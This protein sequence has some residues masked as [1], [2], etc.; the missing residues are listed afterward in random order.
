MKHS[1]LGLF[2]PRK[3]FV[4]DEEDAVRAAPAVRHEFLDY[5]VANGLISQTV[6][7]A[8]A[9]EQTVTN[10]LTGAILVKHNYITHQA[11]TKAILNF[12]P[13]RIAAEKAATSRIP[14]ALLRAKKIHIAHSDADTIYVASLMD[15]AEVAPLIEEYYPDKSIAWVAFIP[16]LFK[17]F[18]DQI[19]RATNAGALTAGEPEQILTY[20]VTRAISEQ[21][22]DIHVE[23]KSDSYTVLFRKL[24]VRELIYEGSRDEY[25]S[26]IARLKDRSGL[27]IAQ[28][29]TAQDGRFEIDYGPKRVDLRVATTVGIDGEKA[30]IRI[31]DPDRL[32][33]SLE[34]L[35]ISRLA[36]WRKAANRQNGLCFICGQTGS[37][38][39]TTLSATLSEQ[40]RFGN[41]I[42][43]IE[44]PVELRT[45]GV[46][47]ITAAP[48]L[49]E[50]FAK[51][52]KNLLRADPDEIAVGEVRDAETARVALSAAETG[53][54][55][56]A[57][58]HAPSILT[59][60]SRLTELGIEPHELR[61]ILR[62]VL[63]QALVRTICPVCHGSGLYKDTQCPHELC[64]GTGYGGRTVI[65]ECA[66]FA[67]PVEVDDIIA[68]ARSGA[69]GAEDLPWPVMIDDAIDKM[70]AGLT[71][72][73]ELERIF[74][75]DFAAAAT[76]RGINPITYGMI[77]IRAAQYPTLPCANPPPV[78]AQAQESPYSADG[79]AGH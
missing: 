7:K 21:A 76:R 16:D 9:M 62:G 6:A 20:L 40:D 51:I 36:E 25:V 12:R 78:A 22:S 13:Q 41:S 61:L 14:I 39:S 50:T 30:V 17:A 79:S 18:L 70:L 77:A 72:S 69:V 34:N 15:E 26:L 4:D 46:T 47:S 10:A 27:D 24:G 32:N 68:R 60:I 48:D 54:L 5:L 31:L 55:I 44:D 74:G 37:G 2:A 29:R 63:V 1:I 75:P 42:Y 43:T 23:P 8:A 64:H 45:A 38:K 67:T 28:T 49:G 35:G 33:T 57:T 11:L 53:H 52:L 71:T 19:G 3:P 59:V 73:D 56:F 58:L 66:Y 65:S